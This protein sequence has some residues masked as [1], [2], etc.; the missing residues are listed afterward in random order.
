MIVFDNVTKQFSDH[1][2]GLRNVS[3]RVEPGDFIF[4]TGNS[5][6]GKTTLMRLLTKEYTPTEGEIYFEET[7]LGEIKMSQVHHLRR[8]IGVVF[9]DY[10]LLPDLNVWENISLPLYIVGTPEAEVERR[11]TDLLRLVGL[12]DKSELFISQL[13][14]GEAQRVSIARALTTGP[15]VIFAD[16]PTGNLDP[17]TSLI[18]ANLFNKIN[19]LGTTVLFATHNHELLAHFKEKRR[20]HLDEGALVEDTAE[21]HAKRKAKKEAADDAGEAK[22]TPEEPAAEEEFE[23]AMPPA[24]KT[25][26][27]SRLFGRKR[28]PAESQ[29]DT[30][31]QETT[32]SANQ[33]QENPL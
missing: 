17:D 23:E 21:K 4:I 25:S 31:G 15:S 8:K 33:D 30:D 5:G 28:K 13:S 26:L 9:Q 22:A 10:K 12:M 14:G 18:I 2:Y 16:E 3:F 7:P 1:D 6:S 20:L 19:E 11:V 29:P 24:Q 32:H 27:L